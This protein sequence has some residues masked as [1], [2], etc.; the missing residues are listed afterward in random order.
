MALR[1]YTLQ[2]PQRFTRRR[3]DPR[4]GR[5]RIHSHH[6]FAFNA[7]T[8]HFAIGGQPLETP[9]CVEAFK[10]FYR[11]LSPRQLDEMGSI[12]ADGII[13]RDPVHE[14]RGLPAL[15]HYMSELCANLRECR[16]EYL[17]QLVGAGS[18]YIKWHMHF[19][20]PQLGSQTITVRGMTH[21]E[22]HDKIHFHEDAYDMGQLLYEHL[23]LL[24]L[25]TRFLKR[26]L[27]GSG[28]P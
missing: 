2:A 28:R 9:R 14:I 10:T 1:V 17:D 20:H 13:F 24:G 26:R 23:P 16:F 11:E 25:A 12:Y 5:L 4:P 7:M 6:N 8:N 22:F 27:A 18:A 19:R 15:H 3:A 21:I